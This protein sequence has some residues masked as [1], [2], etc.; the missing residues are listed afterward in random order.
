MFSNRY[1]FIYSTILIIIVGVL[2][3]IAASGLQPFQQANIK[4]EKIQYIL[5][6]AHIENNKQN[7]EKTY[8]EHLIAELLVDETGNIL[9]T[10]D[11]RERTTEPKPFDIKIKEAFKE[12]QEKGKSQLPI[13]I[14]KKGS[15]T[16]YVFPMFG[17]GLWGPI[18][19]YLALRSDFE[20]IEGAVFDHKGETPGLGAEIANSTFQ[21]QFP[22]KKIFKD[23]ELR[24]V[25]LVKGGKTN[26]LYD[27]MHD[28]D[29]ISGGTITSNGTTQMIEKTLSFFKSFIEKNRKNYQHE[30]K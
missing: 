17:T 15:D 29:A 13:F 14:L 10:Y 5:N 9:N 28:V 23:D 25:H 12:F 19:G 26:P 30:N 1:I 27:P 20:T 4:T 18:W 24:P 2:L 21:A 6:S 22:G 16:I 7:A 8:K 11:Y 3:A